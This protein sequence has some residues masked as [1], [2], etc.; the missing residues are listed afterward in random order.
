MACRRILRDFIYFIEVCKSCYELNVRVC[1]ILEKYYNYTSMFSFDTLMTSIPLSLNLLN[2]VSCDSSTPTTKEKNVKQIPKIYGEFK[3]PISYLPE[4]QVFPLSETVQTDIELATTQNAESKSMYEHL[5]QP[6][7]PF[8]QETIKEWKQSYTTNTEYLGETQLILK[9]VIKFDNT[10]INHKAVM[11]IW[12]DT[13]ENDFFLE[14]YC[15]IEWDFFKSLNRSS[16]F[17][18][19]LSVGNMLSPVMSLILPI[20][21]LIV[22]FI[23]L[24]LRGLPITFSIY[25]EVLKDIAKNHFIGKTLMNLRS[26][27]WD[28]I[29]YLLITIGLY[30]YQ[31]YQNVL[32]CTRFYNHIHVINESLCDLREYIGTSIRN[33]DL[34][35]KLHNKKPSY[36]VFCSITKE[37]SNR[38]RELHGE[39]DSVRPFDVTLGIMGK[40]GHVGYL[41]KCYYEIHSNMEYERSLK[42]S[43]GFEGYLDNLRGVSNHLLQG[44]MNSVTFD[45]KKKCQFI[46]QYYPPY[47][48]KI[49]VKNDCLLK[50]NVIITGPNAS[51]KTTYLKTTTI[52]IIFSQQLGCGFY[53]SGTI[54]PYTHIHSYLNIPDTSERD[55]LFQAESRRCKDIIDIIRENPENKGFRH[56]CIFD[57]LYSGT[58]PLEAAKSAQAFLKYLTKFGNVDFVLTTHYVSICKKLAKSN[59]ITNYKM[60]VLLKESGELEYTYKIVKGISKVQGAVRILEQMNYP[61]EIL[62]DVR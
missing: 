19:I 42:Y 33:M 7:H 5:F 45:K 49:H 57:E 60:D 26:I 2:P 36:G 44:N 23:I 12:K 43:F 48:D 59:M 46:K 4:N 61:K 62:D 53:E 8:A 41:L 51:G 15:Y 32:L 29:A 22:P 10:A 31:I 54:N 14:K 18:Q 58:N 55:S 13:K 21:F 28:K 40:M 1:S 39:L 35:V 11:N 50:K 6:S 16:S 27:T 37:H 24:K 25:V 30:F 56:Y 47:F 52:N 38:L 34:F 9:D 20:I 17:L 3:L